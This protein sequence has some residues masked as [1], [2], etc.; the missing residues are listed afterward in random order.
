MAMWRLLVR[1]TSE[2]LRFSIC[3]PLKLKRGV[4]EKCSWEV[5]VEKPLSWRQKLV[6]D[7]FL[8]LVTAAL[9]EQIPLRDFNARGENL[10]RPEPRLR[11]T[12]IENPPAMSR[13]LLQLDRASGQMFLMPQA[14]P[15]SPRAIGDKAV[16]WIQTEAPQARLEA[17][18][19]LMKEEG[20]PLVKLKPTSRRPTDM[21]PQAATRKALRRRE[22]DLP[23]L[24]APLAN[25]PE[26][27]TSRTIEGDKS[28]LS[29]GEA[30]LEWE[31][32]IDLIWNGRWAMRFSVG[33]LPISEELQSRV[34]ATLSISF[35]ANHPIWNAFSVG[36]FLRWSNDRD[37]S[38]LR[39]NTFGNGNIQLANGRRSVAI[40]ALSGHADVTTNWFNSRLG[41]AG[42]FSSISS[43]W[44]YDRAKTTLD[45]WTP[46]GQGR[47]L[48]P[49]MEILPIRSA[50]NGFVA[51]MAPH[52]A[53]YSDAKISSLT[54][55]LG[56]QWKNPWTKAQLGSVGFDGIHT[57]L[58]YRAGKLE[59][60]SENSSNQTSP[61]ILLNA[62]WLNLIVMMNEAD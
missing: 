39:I 3:R 10:S 21:S 6:N 44:S 23:P 42:G 26:T 38:E 43:D 18:E 28:D 2:L 15:A 1:E 52:F 11:S 9:H 61:T 7:N 37:V 17:I 57:L 34:P 25:S 14:A 20:Y 33:G 36:G 54:T 41:V 12:R 53:S 59:K 27:L 31:K 58:G 35:E 62:I 29:S 46:K 16:W 30:E 5:A 24:A 22:L 32:L 56:W 4:Q 60:T 51:R 8:F 19:G 50:E 55:E 48:E 40:A 47:V 49:W 13:G 45:V